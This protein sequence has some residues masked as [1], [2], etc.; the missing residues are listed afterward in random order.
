[1]EIY[2]GT[3]EGKLTVEGP[4]VFGAPIRIFCRPHAVEKV[5]K[6]VN[7]PIS[8]SLLEITDNFS[9]TRAHL[10]LV[11]SKNYREVLRDVLQRQ[12]VDSPVIALFARSDLSPGCFLCS[13]CISDN[14]YVARSSEEYVLDHL[15][16][17]GRDFVPEL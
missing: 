8:P 1:M 17:F 3:Y 10:G 14:V 6:F 4:R 15:T 11:S 9:P 5:P 16:R 13:D 2:V 12:R 7:L